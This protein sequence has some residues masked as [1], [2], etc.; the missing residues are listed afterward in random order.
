MRILKF[1]MAAVLALAVNLTAADPFYIG[2]WKIVSAVPAPWASSELTPDQPEMKDLS[3]KTIAFKPKEIEGPRQAACKG[4]KYRVVNSPVEGLFQGMF[5]ETHRRDKSVD[6]AKMAA[7]AG[8]H[9][10]PGA[11]W[12][13]LETGCGNEL[14]FHFIDPMTAAFGLNNV[15]YTMKK[16]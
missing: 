9:G 8:F 15:V 4:P 3:G 13:T 10:S 16:Q 1:P 14:D 6:P 7:Q 11:K 5:D 2:A 12:K